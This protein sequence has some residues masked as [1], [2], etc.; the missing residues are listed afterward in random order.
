MDPWTERM[1]FESVGFR[2]DRPSVW[3]RPKE[4]KDDDFTLAHKEEK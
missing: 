4:K 2:Q 1:Q 3:D